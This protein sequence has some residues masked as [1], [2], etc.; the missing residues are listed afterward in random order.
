MRPGI[1]VS[2]G[3]SVAGVRC[4]CGRAR[5]AGGQ[6]VGVAGVGVAPG[7]VGLQA[8][9]QHRVVRVVRAAQDARRQ[10]HIRVHAPGVPRALRAAAR[11]ATAPTIGAPAT[12][13]LHLARGRPAAP[14]HDR[15]AGADRARPGILDCRHPQA[16]G[17]LPSSVPLRTQ[18][19]DGPSRPGRQASSR[20]RIK[21]TQ[22]RLPGR[23]WEPGRDWDRGRG[24]GTGT[25][26]GTCRRRHSL[27]PR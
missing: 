8:A 7:Q 24:T 19:A 10:R 11:L 22:V 18:P 25:G 26:T 4:G 23:D 20:I 21:R 17:Y 12:G 14:G 2:G 16:A 13:T 6:H 15:R 3:P 9:G 27:R 1:W 5:G